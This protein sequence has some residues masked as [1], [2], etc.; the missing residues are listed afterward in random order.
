MEKSK[1]FLAK[2]GLRP[3]KSLGQH[4]LEDHGIIDK[5]ITL[6]QLNKNDVVVEIGPG[7]GAL[8][9]PV[10]PYICHLIAIEKDQLLINLLRKK[11]SA[12]EGKKITLISG[13][14]LKIDF[15]E[16]SNDFK[17]K[18]RIIGNIPYNISSPLLERL[19]LYRAYI[20][21]AVL[22]FQHEFALRLI[23][24]PGQRKCSAL[25][26]IS[27]YYAEISPIIKIKRDAFYPIPKVDSMVLKMDFERP[28]KF[29]AKD[30]MVFRKIVKSAFLFRRKT[31]LNSLEKATVSLSREEIAKALE[32]CNI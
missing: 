20:K 7:T 19:I 8:T 5:I 27:Q 14:A 9:I 25:T 31:I 23:A 3:K 26:I 21:S 16:I 18:I 4:F 13:D 24:P 12:E 17:Q 22:M 28:Y 29:Q 30:E 2:S 15:K 6:I 32:E 11:L 10:L 1:Y